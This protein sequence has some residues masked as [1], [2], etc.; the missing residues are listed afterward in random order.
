M[1]T[2]Y[3][4]DQCSVIVVPSFNEY[5][6]KVLIDSYPPD[7]ILAHLLL[8]FSSCNGSDTHLEIVDRKNRILNATFWEGD[9]QLCEPK[10]LVKKCAFIYSIIFE[11]SFSSGS[12]YRFLIISVRI[13]QIDLLICH[14]QMSYTDLICYFPARM[15]IVY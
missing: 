9:S 5:R 10:S 4:E 14:R 1:N 2:E 3:P 6:K 7:E 11:F 15:R 12:R 13:S 8:C